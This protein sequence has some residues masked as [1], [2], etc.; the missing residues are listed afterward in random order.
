MSGMLGQWEVVVRTPRQKSAT[1]GKSKPVVE[2]K[3]KSE[4]IAKP[5]RKSLY[6]EISIH[7]ALIPFI[8][9]ALNFTCKRHN[10]HVSVFK[11][12]SAATE[13]PSIFSLSDDE[14]DKKESQAKKTKK[15]AQS[16]KHTE[17]KSPEVKKVKQPK[18]I[19][20]ALAQVSYHY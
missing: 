10:V 2:E 12:F 13:F 9:N 14:D 1:N 20:S 3:K 16:Q 4:T 19:E 5:S 15:T 6:F 18:S 17:K 8:L 7:T 11:S